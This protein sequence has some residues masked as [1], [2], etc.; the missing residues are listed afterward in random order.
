MVLPS[1][2]CSLESSDDD[3]ATTLSAS[4]ARSDVGRLASPLFLLEREVSADP[5]SASF[6]HSR[7]SIEKSMARSHH[8]RKSSRDSGGVQ[9]SQ[10]ERT[11][12]LFAQRDPHNLLER[13][14]DQAFQGEGA[15][16]TM[17]SGQTKMEDAES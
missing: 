17:L 11:K 9:G 3:L 12:I 1:R 2:R 16:Q 4:E 6:A 13:E 15:A 8:K 5:C 7:S 14:A 10:M